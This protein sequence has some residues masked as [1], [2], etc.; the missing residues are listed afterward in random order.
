MI[1]SIYTINSSKSDNFHD[2]TVCVCVCGVCVVWG[3]QQTARKCACLWASV[4]QHPWVH[5]CM[6]VSPTC[7]G[8]DCYIGLSDHAKPFLYSLKSSDQML[9]AVCLPAGRSS[10]SAVVDHQPF[11][12]SAA[13]LE[14][15]GRAH[16]PS[17]S[18]SQ[19][20]CILTTNQEGPPFRVSS[21]TQ[22]GPTAPQTT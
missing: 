18:Q 3:G 19:S 11:G 13:L 17:P 20:G 6:G 8:A 12:L 21:P 16:E 5:G 9:N 1:N 7:R 14:A 10:S 15:V 4:C 2:V 22:L